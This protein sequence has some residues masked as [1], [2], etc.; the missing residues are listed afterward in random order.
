ML[1]RVVLQDGKP[2]TAGVNVAK[3]PFC[4]YHVAKQFRNMASRRGGFT[5]SLLPTGF[6]R[7]GAASQPGVL[8][9][10]P[11]VYLASLKLKRSGM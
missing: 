1:M 10:F 5:D 8:L 4:D 7:T 6:C 2:C 9:S 11:A 3:C